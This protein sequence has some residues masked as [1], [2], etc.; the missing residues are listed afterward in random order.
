MKRAVVSMLL[1]VVM[2]MSC[3]LSKAPANADIM[4]PT[5]AA[6]VQIPTLPACC[7]S[8][9]TPVRSARVIASRSVNIREYAS[10]HSRDVGDLY[11]NETILV[12]DCQDGW[13]KMGNHQ[14]VKAKYLSIDCFPNLDKR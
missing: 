12:I 7:S 10:E 14:W 11:Y 1:M 13:V 4:A 6:T 2:S 3:N 5:V 9:P 8:A